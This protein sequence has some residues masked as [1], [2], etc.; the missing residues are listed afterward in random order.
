MGRVGRTDRVDGY[1]LSHEPFEYAVENVAMFPV[2]KPAIR[3]GLQR[4][5]RLHL[6]A[7]PEKEP[8]RTGPESLE[9]VG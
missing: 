1:E 7:I 4:V 3:F 9:T 8:P 6:E 5:E 2:V